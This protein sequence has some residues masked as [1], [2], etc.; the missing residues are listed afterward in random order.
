MPISTRLCYM[1]LPIPLPKPAVSSVDGWKTLWKFCAE[2][3]FSS[4]DT[5]KYG[6]D[7]LNNGDVAITEFYSSALYGKI[8]A[9]AESSEH[10]ITNDNWALVDIADGT[11]YIA[12][13]VGILDKAGRTDE[14]TE[15]V[16]AFAEWFGDAEVTGGLGGRIRYLPLQYRG[17]HIGLRFRYSGNLYAG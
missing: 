3:V 11:Y 7:P 14:E 4:D 16:K 8:D 12:E 6:F 13:Y 9:A 5:Y 1:P 15:I 17:S 10:P 2:G